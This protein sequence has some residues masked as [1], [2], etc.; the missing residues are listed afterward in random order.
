ML[1]LRSLFWYHHVWWCALAGRSLLCRLGVVCFVVNIFSSE[2]KLTMLLWMAAG[3]GV[4]AQ[5]AWTLLFRIFPSCGFKYVCKIVHA[6]CCFAVTHR[7]R[8]Y[9]EY[10]CTKSVSVIDV[11]VHCR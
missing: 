9:A 3:R 10:E 4:D 1:C 5:A 7:I 6:P 8:A 11:T 2:I